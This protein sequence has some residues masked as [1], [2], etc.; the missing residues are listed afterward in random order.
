MEI[1]FILIRRAL[2]E[3]INE[4]LA[5]LPEI[6]VGVVLFVLFYYFAGVVRWIVRRLIQR[7][8]MSES[9][10]LALGR[11]SQW[12]TVLIGLLVALAIALPAFN[13]GELVQLLGITSVAIGF[14][15]RDILQNLLAGVLLLLTEPFSVGDQ[16]IVTDYEGTVETVQTRATTLKTYD[17]RRVVIP[18]AD[19]FTESVI[20]NTAFPIRRSE[21]DIGIGYG[22]DLARAQEL[23]VQA[24]RSVP[25]ALEDPAP[26]ALVWD[27]GASSLILRA[28]WW[29][30]SWRGDVVQIMDQVLGAIAEALGEAGID[31]PFDTQ[32]V[33]FHDQTEATDGDRARQREGWPVGP[34]GAPRPMTIAGSLQQLA[35]AL[36]DKGANAA[37]P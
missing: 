13:A 28:R 8:G 23:I 29:T 34:N 32:V 6:A 2:E 9:A 19:M 5:A 3:M 33:L 18:N 10:S 4:L 35:E 26:E 36:A 31:M 1:D 24:I 37:R 25:D 7:S 14:A 22:D 17:G 15:F 21:Y 27:L 12:G 20:V 11:L 30:D 16:I